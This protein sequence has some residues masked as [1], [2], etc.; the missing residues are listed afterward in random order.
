MI[1]RCSQRPDRDEGFSLIELLVVVVIIGILAA[2]S[3]P[4]YLDQQRAARN[5]SAL[6]DLRNLVAIETSLEAE[7]GLTD[8]AVAIADEGWSASSSEI[9]ACAALA[10]GAT[11]ITLTVWHERRSFFY[12]WRRSTSQI[13]SAD[14][15]AAQTDCTGFGVPVA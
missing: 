1:R 7:G 9:I 10:P 2:I 3:I 5:A 13:Q 11:D 4:R 14:L 12:S 8:D 6:S 15:P